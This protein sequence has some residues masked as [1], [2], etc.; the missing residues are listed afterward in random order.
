MNHLFVPSIMRPSI[1]YRPKNYK[2]RLSRIS[3][4]HYSK[5]TRAI[6]MKLFHITL[7]STMLLLNLLIMPGSLSTSATGPLPTFDQPK[8][9]A[10]Y[11]EDDLLW[12]N[13]LQEDTESVQSHSDRHVNLEDTERTYDFPQ[14]EGPGDNVILTEPLSLDTSIKASGWF[15]IQFDTLPFTQYPS[16]IAIKLVSEGVVIGE[17]TNP[18]YSDNAESYQFNITLSEGTVN[19]LTLQIYFIEHQGTTTVNLDLEGGIFVTLPIVPSASGDDDADDEDDDDTSDDDTGDDDSDDDTSDDDSDDTSGEGNTALEEKEDFVG[20]IWMWM[21]V[22]AA[23]LI[24]IGII[25]FILWKKS[26]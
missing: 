17:D 2:Y 12:M 15:G 19:D 24:V 7:I 6:T 23:I 22:I 14:R 1:L 5:N 8:A 13:A 9:Y 26:D 3:S 18:Y 20:S 21:I 10:H 16:N 25:A 4:L 11:S